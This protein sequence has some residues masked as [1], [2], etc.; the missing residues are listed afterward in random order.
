MAKVPTPIA[1]FLRGE[2]LAVAGVLRTSDQKGCETLGIVC[3]VGGCPMIFCEPVDFDHKC[4]RW[5]FQ[6]T[7][8]VPK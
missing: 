4:M 7:G 6:R 5:W 3:I 1:E 8:K 2:R